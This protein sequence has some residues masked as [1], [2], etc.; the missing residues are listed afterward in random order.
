MSNRIQK[1]SSAGFPDAGYGNQYINSRQGAVRKPER[2]VKGKPRAGKIYMALVFIFMYAPIILLMIFSFNDS[3]SRSVWN[4]FS[5]RWYKMLF[6]DSE[7]IHAIQVTLIVSV[8]AAIIST[9]LGTAAAIGIVNMRKY[10]RK[11]AM[12]V[13]NIP[14][15]NPD[16]IMGVSLMLLFIFCYQILHLPFFQLGFGTLLIAHITFDTPYVILSV[17]PKLRQMDVKQYEAARDLGATNLQA[18]LQVVLPQIMPGIVT[19][20]I[21]SFTMSIDDVVVSYFNSGATSQTLGV[22]IF[23]MTKKRISPE[24]NALCTLMFV[25]VL[26]LLLIINFR[27]LRAG[28]EKERT[29]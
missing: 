4:G 27:E 7:I 3:K 15:M 29:I 5:L 26:A 9:V 14:M 11:L 21:L 13:N 17:M 18:F 12:S 8:C 1:K 23:S 24:I 20:M 22:L 16:I 25:V 28:K 19:G 10:P 6:N 2:R